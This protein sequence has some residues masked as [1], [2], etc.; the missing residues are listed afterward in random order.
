MIM[1]TLA[2]EK[3]SPRGKPVG[4]VCGAASWCR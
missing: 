2:L 4:K 3:K 1:G